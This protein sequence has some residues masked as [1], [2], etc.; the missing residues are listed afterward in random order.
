MLAIQ[1]R[2]VLVLLLLVLLPGAGAIA[3]TISWRS[4]APLCRT[5]GSTSPPQLQRAKEDEP[6]EEPVGSGILSVQV[7][8]RPVSVRLFHLRFRRA[9]LWWPG[10]QWRTATCAGR[11]GRVVL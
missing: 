3:A 5:P 6:G 7:N 11:K 2:L 9:E 8:C 1:P 10:R 4:L